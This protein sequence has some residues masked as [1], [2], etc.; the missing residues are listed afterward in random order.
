M[1]TT[2]TS[3]ASA[4]VITK[5]T[6][7]ADVSVADLGKLATD[8]LAKLTPTQLGE[9]SGCASSVVTIGFEASQPYA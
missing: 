3:T 5:T 7:M 1:A 2:T 4:V 9:L 6:A 8:I